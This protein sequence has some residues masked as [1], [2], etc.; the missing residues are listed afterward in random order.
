VEARVTEAK[1]AGELVRAEA[2]A[3]QAKVAEAQQV[4]EKVFNIYVRFDSLNLRQL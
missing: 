2:E 1:E 3:A 4:K